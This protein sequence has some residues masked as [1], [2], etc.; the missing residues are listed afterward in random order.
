MLFRSIEIYHFDASTQDHLFQVLL[1]RLQFLSK[2]EIA[3][4]VGL[5]TDAATSLF[6]AI[7]RH[8]INSMFNIRQLAGLGSAS[9]QKLYEYLGNERVFS[10]KDNIQINIPF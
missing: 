8:S 6:N 10:E 9:I 2:E 4:L 5:K 1:G 3:N 7:H